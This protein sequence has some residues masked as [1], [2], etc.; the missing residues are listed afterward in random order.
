M[1]I[2]GNEIGFD[3]DA[4]FHHVAAF[5]LFVLFASAAIKALSI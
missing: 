5:S 1:E 3:W 4:T 2:Q